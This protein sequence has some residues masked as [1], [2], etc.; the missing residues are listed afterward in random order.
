MVLLLI[1]STGMFMSTPRL[2]PGVS[3][4][5][6]FFDPL[7]LSSNVSS[8]RFKFYREA[9]LKHGRLAMLA[10]VGFPVAEQYHPLFGGGIDAPSYVAYQET[11]LQVFWPWVVLAISISEITSVLS[12]DNPFEEGEPWSIR[13]DHEVGNMR[14]DPLGI[15]PTDE[16]VL[17]DTKTKELNNGRV[18]MGAIALMVLQECTT[19]EKLF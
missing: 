3:R 19:G 1:A 10:A 16:A 17:W 14:F 9:E 8:G 2:L 11:P 18:A 15:K 4:P 7:E 6:G 5:L 12:F 13:A